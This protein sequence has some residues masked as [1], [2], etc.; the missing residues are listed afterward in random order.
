MARL[1]EL[2]DSGLLAGCGYDFESHFIG[3]DG[4]RRHYIDEGE[5]SPVVMV[6]G[7][8]T[9]SFYYRGL[10]NSLKDRHRCI[11][12]DHMGCGFSD[13]PDDSAYEYTLKQ[14]IDDL[15]E[16]L[17]SLGVYSNVTLIVHD[18]GGAIGF[19][20]AARHPEAVKRLVVLNTAAF[21]L[22]PGKPLPSSLRLGRDSIVGEVL[23]RGLNLFSW[24]TV[25]SWGSEY[26]LS[27]AVRS[28]Y[29]APHDSWDR[30]R[31]V[32]RFVQ[33]IPLTPGDRAWDELQ[34][35][36]AGLDRLQGLPMQVFWGLKD[37][38]FDGHFLAEWERRFPEAE[39]H[40]FEDAGHLIL[41]EEPAAILS[42]LR[43]DEGGHS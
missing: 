7:N 17:E 37:F 35:V 5:G 43:M 13:A 39:V 11:V 14:R 4:L 20:W 38:V 10:V 18:W 21:G 23:M 42:R 32:A 25:R 29:L 16:L 24:A 19:G 26:G 22:P 28:A 9:W 12:P 3:A 2:R 15:E 30:R 1:E 31:S 33:D 27:S 8:P 41:E 6:H 34:R 40:R 36:E